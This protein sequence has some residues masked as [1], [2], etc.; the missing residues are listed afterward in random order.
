[1]AIRVPGTKGTDIPEQIRSIDL[2]PTLLDL[3]GVERPGM[4]EGHSVAPWIRGEAPPE[5]RPY[6]GETSL[7]WI[8]FKVPG[9]ERPPLPPMD[10]MSYIDR[11]FN[12][13][14]V[15][16]PEYP[17]RVLAAKQRC[18]R[19]RDWKIVCTP[20]KDGGRHFGLFH[21]PTDVDSRDDLADKRP[22]VLAPMKAALEKWMD[23]HQETPIREI[24]GGPEP[25]S[26][27][28]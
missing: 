24:F 16:L 19:T 6:Y 17:E 12:Y 14:F 28:S 10:G 11:D 23:Q 13:Q 9:V 8:Q 5:D 15:L 20:T 25:G 22:E 4:W 27:P 1:M 7:P 21:I 18:L 2:S 3:L 26:Q